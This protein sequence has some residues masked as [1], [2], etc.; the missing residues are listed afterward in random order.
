[1]SGVKLLRDT[2]TYYHAA[3]S[4][5]SSYYGQVQVALAVGP[6]ASAPCSMCIV[7]VILQANWWSDWHGSCQVLSSLLACQALW[8]C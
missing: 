8:H 4:L 5:P 3:I 7:C 2:S 6:A 1:M